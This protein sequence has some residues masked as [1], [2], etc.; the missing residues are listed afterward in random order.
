NYRQEKFLC[1]YSEST[2]HK[3]QSVVGDV[4]INLESYDPKEQL[5]FQI[6]RI[7]TSH[8]SSLSDELTNFLSFSIHMLTIR[9]SGEVL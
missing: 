2:P 5:L 7:I 4:R 8:F 6:S 1:I 3:T 9:P